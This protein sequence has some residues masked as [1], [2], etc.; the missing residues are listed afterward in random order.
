MLRSTDPWDRARAAQSLVFGDEFGLPRRAVGPLIHALKDRHP[1]VRQ[2]AAEALSRIDPVGMDRKAIAA[3]LI[4]L[5]DDPDTQYYIIETLGKLGPAAGA[6]TAQLRVFL[7]AEDCYFQD[8]SLL[9]LSRIAR[10][11]ALPELISAL[12]DEESGL[13]YV[14]VVALGE[15]GPDAKEA[16]PAL[17]AHLLDVSAGT[18]LAAANSLLSIEPASAPFVS[19]ALRRRVEACRVN[20]EGK[21]NESNVNEEILL[22]AMIGPAA[23]WAT[24]MLE[25]FIEKEEAPQSIAALAKIDPE[26]LRRIASRS[27]ERLRSPEPKTRLEAIKSLARLAR[28][29][30]APE[31]I[32]ESLKDSSQA[33]RDEARGALEAFTDLGER[34]VPL[35]VG[36]LRESDDS[37]TL[38]AA[39]S[40]LVNT[41]HEKA[42][43]ILAKLAT[44]SS[45]RVR[46]YAIEAI[47]AVP[48]P[49][50]ASALVVALD[51]PD[52]EIREAAS[53]A[54]GGGAEQ[55]SPTEAMLDGLTSRLST[56]S[57]SRVRMAAM[58]SLGHYGPAAHAA[59]PALV[60]ALRDR[61]IRS[62]A[63]VTLGEIGPAAADAVPELLRV[64]SEERDLDNR[65]SAV[66]ALG[67]IGSIAAAPELQRMLA[68]INDRT[69]R[70]HAACALLQIRHK[71]TPDMVE[72]LKFAIS[73]RQDVLR[74]IVWQ[75]LVE[76]KNPDPICIPLLVELTTGNYSGEPE[77][78]A[79]QALGELCARHQIALD[80]KQNFGPEV[81][82]RM[83]AV[84]IPRLQQL[85]DQESD[86]IEVVEAL[87][88]IGLHEEAAVQILT[89]ALFHSN[90]R[91][92]GVAAEQLSRIGPRARSAVPAL[93][94]VLA[95]EDDSVFDAALEALNQIDP[96]LLR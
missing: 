35:L 93:F 85:A 25:A 80:P 81:L 4:P 52:E 7:L 90:E 11:D 19:D 45:P 77:Y 86:N 64:L 38:A 82:G 76:L 15:L 54:L 37:E 8:V 67:Q 65:T 43:P 40:A 50:A 33:V 84:A 83:G 51:D 9:A 92:R 5:L 72:P 30:G 10:R 56:D 27:I 42:A 95:D 3:A 68:S 31:A 49:V 24:P 20:E 12:N 39:T 47:V 36:I 55:F 91:I 26:A 22:L 13:S 73:N 57:S 61:R 78:R 88:R 94:A 66:S 79:A 6:S 87:G 46:R 89:G 48:C 69:I 96:S 58:R 29:E 75:L 74:P 18:F 32:A 59:V 28:A 44:E 62:Q 14:A 34:V 60:R 71:V 23:N 63:A 16:A 21:E 53:E 41:L 2:S 1:R 17:T 70:S